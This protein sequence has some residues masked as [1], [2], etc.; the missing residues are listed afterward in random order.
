M[1]PKK[2]QLS[3]EKLMIVTSEGCIDLKV[4]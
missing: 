2:Y 4:R 1:M 3:S